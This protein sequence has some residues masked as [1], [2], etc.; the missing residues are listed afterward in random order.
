MYMSYNKS[1][2]R[3]F[4]LDV[5][6]LEMIRNQCDDS[7]FADLVVCVFFSGCSSEEKRPQQDYRMC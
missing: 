5:E 4:W 1:G 6:L 3:S 7:R 2:I